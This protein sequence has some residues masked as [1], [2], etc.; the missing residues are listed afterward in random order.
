M[1]APRTETSDRPD[2]PGKDEKPSGSQLSVVQLSAGALAA[3]SSAVV[4][5]FFG[6]AGTL[7]GA[8][9]ASV[10]STLS[11]TLYSQ[12]L[13]KTNA[14]LRRVREQVTRRPTAPQPTDATATA[15]LPA[16]LDPRRP[17]A[18]RSRIRWPRIAVYAAAVFVLAMGIVTG[19]ELV[20][21]QPVSALV[22][23]TETSRSTTL[24][25]L[26]DDISS[27]DD[28]S[29]PEPAPTAPPTPTTEAPATD[30]PDSE[31]RG[32]EDEESASP[33]ATTTDAPEEPTDVE[34]TEEPSPEAPET[35]QAP[36][37]EADPTP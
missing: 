19:I 5:S 3:V 1:T 8:A 24:G 28:E 7:I 18:R 2:A 15:V 4:A 27:S 29:T 34:P 37:D 6:V 11:A 30:A 35:S 10:I 20:S 25:T 12:S 22:G 31:D 14:G 17:P 33:T 16:H 21:Q 13:Q 32:T 9:V 26:T 36:D 23:V